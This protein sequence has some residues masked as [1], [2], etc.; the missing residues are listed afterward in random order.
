MEEELRVF[1]CRTFDNFAGSRD[2]LKR[3][4]VI[5][6]SAV[7]ERGDSEAGHGKCSANG[8]VEIVGENGWDQLLRLELIDKIF[9]EQ[10]R[11]DDTGFLFRIDFEDLPERG[12]V[13]Q[14]TAL[15]EGLSALAV[16]AGA[17]AQRNVVAHRNLYGRNDV[18]G[19]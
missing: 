19:R 1:G 7:A 16:R 18:F 2:N 6:L 3:D 13:E 4:A 12:H 15:I 5:S 17:C 10:S 11:F 9:P 14:D 8:H